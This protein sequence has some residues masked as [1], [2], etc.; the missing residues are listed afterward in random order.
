VTVSGTNFKLSV[1]A[2]RV[3][4]D[5]TIAADG[6]S[7]SGT[8]T[9]GGSLPLTLIRATADTAWKDPAP[10]SVQLVAVEPDVKLEVLDWGGPSSG[11]TLVLVP[12][13]GNTAH[14]FDVF[15]PK[16]TTRYRVIGFTRRGF[17][18]STAPASGYGANRL[19]DDVLAVIDALAI[20]KP[21]LA[22]HSAG[23]Q[24]LSSIG[25]R[26][27]DK[28]A[29]LVYL[30][31]GYSYAFHAP[32]IDPLPPPAPD[33]P[34][35]PI[36]RVIISGSQQYTNIPVP[37]LAIYALPQDVGPTA[38]AEMKAQMEQR[39][40]R[41]EAQAKAFENGLQTARVVRIPRASHYVFQSNEADV[42]REMETFIGT[43]K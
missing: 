21:V 28:V 33:A 15:A 35:P 4:Y 9:Q 5:G 12:G 6:N 40:V 30:D 25:S 13:H 43:L 34:I 11:R 27:P 24:E 3:A 20:R 14:I 19:G 2:L 23:G 1:A 8:L 10:H 41:A 18:S 39:N 32:G 37:I 38:T 26:H 36:S 7:I 42:L 31:A 17:G 29:G 22:G 16:L